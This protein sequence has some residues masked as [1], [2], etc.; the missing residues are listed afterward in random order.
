VAKVD[1]M[2]QS[3]RIWTNGSNS[4]GVDQLNAT[5]LQHWGSW[6]CYY[7]MD[8]CVDGCIVEEN[9]YPSS[10]GCYGSGGVHCWIEVGKDAREMKNH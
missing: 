9:C 10:C 3:C 5:K 6:E 2:L 7:R 4:S 8:K 1:S